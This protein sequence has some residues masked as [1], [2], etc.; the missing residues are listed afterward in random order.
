MSKTRLSDHLIALMLLV[1]VVAGCK[2]LQSMAKP[3]VLKS[4][5]GKFQLTVPGG[6]HENASLNDKAEIKA[7]NPLEE[8]YVIVLTEPKADFTGEMSLDEFTRITRESIMS[9]VEAPDASEPRPVTVNGNSGRAY[10]LEGAVSKVKLAYRI[11]TI[12]TPDHFHQVISW[13][14]RSRRDKNEATLQNVTNSFRPTS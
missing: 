6:W 1:S 7:A 10:E 11:T 5:D 8:M 4:S 14:L 13:T 12:E 9:N 2:Q 3:T